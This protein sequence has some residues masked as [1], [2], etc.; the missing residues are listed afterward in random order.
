MKK[1]FKNA[2]IITMNGRT[3]N[4]VLVENG[5]I[6]AVDNDIT[7][8]NTAVIDL[9][10]RT[11]LP[12]FIDAHSHLTSLAASFMQ[13]DL[14]GC[15]SFD[16]IV[17]RI[18]LFINENNIKE[19]NW[20]IGNGYDHTLL[21]EKRHPDAEC[22]DARLGNY[23]IL[24]KHISNHF[25][26]INAKAAASLCQSTDNGILQEEEFVRVI[27][28]IPMPDIDEYLTAYK[29]ALEQYARFGITSV[30]EGMLVKEMLPL[31]QSLLDSGILN[32]DLVAYA[33]ADDADIIYSSLADWA[34]GY[35][36]KFRLG[37][38][39]IILDGSPQGKTAWMT[40]PYKNSGN[41]RGSGN[42]SDNELFLALL[43]S[44]RNERQILAH[45]NGDAAANQFIDAVDKIKNETDFDLINPV[46]IHAQLLDINRLDDV[47]RLNIIPSFFIAH[48]YYWGDVH[49][50]NFGFERASK[51]SP[52]K[53]CVDKNIL[54][55][56]HQDTPVI[57]SDM[58][59][60]IWCAVNRRT[61]NGVTLG[62]QQRIT[63][64][65]A[66]KAV[67]IN[68]AKQYGEAGDKGSIEVGKRADF[69]VLDRNI[70]TVAD[71]DIKSVNITHTIS[72]GEIIY[73]S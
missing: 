64:Y 32:L 72:N 69:V 63:T 20:V 3:V 33:S 11:M 50:E 6:I 53:Q 70:L 41:Y 14:Q 73:E 4:S 61:K 13:A 48:C 19:N 36:N 35:K 43:K 23:K 25:G 66:L 31:Y 58:I 10:G 49:I 28:K 67:T 18:E 15:T 40:S 56:F 21:R 34:N 59:E 9:E 65:D 30:Q 22:L 54:Y 2:N 71:E 57:K 29:K 55:T 51:I 38:C 1:L 46:M 27:K 24:I 47:K 26:V 5:R 52:V 8:P 68:A 37:G 42:M 39:K 44:A 60:T 12:A 45:C 17:N 16:D 62:E 7:Q